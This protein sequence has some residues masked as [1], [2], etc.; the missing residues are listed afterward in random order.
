M[1]YHFDDSIKTYSGKEL[2]PLR[3]YLEYGLLGTSI[4]SWVGPCNVPLSEMVD[5]EDVRANSVITSDQMLHF[6]LELFDSHLVAGVL[7]QRLFAEKAIILIAE[8]GKNVSLKDLVRRGDDIFFGQKKLNI[9]IATL[10]TN[11]VLLHIGIN[12]TTEGTPIET[13]S[14][15]NF[16]ISP[17]QFALRMMEAVASEWQDILDATH[18]IKTV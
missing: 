12:V 8:M 3:N 18:K 4:V 15:E 9:S 5:G 6:I 10:S 11:S 1:K 7:L 14:L 17:K 2:A 13:C 16:S